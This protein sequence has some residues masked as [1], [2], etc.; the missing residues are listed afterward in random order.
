MAKTSLKTA[1]RA[2]KS[3]LEAP[4]P[5]EERD[6]VAMA[7]GYAEDVCAD[8]K[9][10]KYG[11]WI[12]L[13]A[14]RF[15]DDLKRAQVT[16]GEPPF[17]WS[18]NRANHACAFM[19]QL[20]HVEGLWGTETITLHPSQAFFL[21]NLFGF[22]N[23]DGSRRFTGALY[24]VARKNAKST[25]AAGIQ[26]YCL[27]EEREEGPQVI[28]AATTGDQA[29]IVWKIAKRMVE[30]N[31]ELREY[32]NVEEF[33]NT[34]TCWKNG[35][36]YRSINAKASTQD[37]LN[38]SCLCFDELHAHKTHDLYNVLR[39]AAG[40][41]SNPLFLYTTTEGF[42]SA[43]PWADMRAFAQHVLRGTVQADHFL[44]IYYS[45][46]DEDDDFDESKWEKANPL[47]G[48]SVKLD[49][50][51]EY[52]LEAKQ[53]PGSLSEFR[54]KRLNR[55]SAAARSWLDLARWNKCGAGKL[56]LDALAG[57]PCWAAFDLASTADMTA[58]RLL[59]LKDG[60]FYTWGRYW[61]PRDAVINR[62]NRG[63][64][65]YEPWVE[66]GW[67]KQTEGNVADYSVIEADILADCQRFQPKRVGYDL[68]NASQIAINLGKQGVN[69]ERFIQGPR[70]YSPAMQACEVA[71][72]SERLRH[73]NDPVLT[74]NMANV[75][76][77][78]DVNLNSAPDRQRSAEKIDGAAALFMAFGLAA[79]EP[80]K[81]E[82]KQFRLMVLGGAR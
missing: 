82:P 6:Y 12:R 36:T 52:A 78:H 62:N 49:K 39:S 77:R 2:S 59:W 50:L 11:A 48:V 28:S 80:P 45:L 54:I 15:L 47:L 37:G 23:H 70:S 27:V 40:A 55:R 29:R 17:L 19:E 60:I 10:V 9:R 16:R 61:V 3:A 57:I 68:W 18:P 1:S 41:R 69:L 64:V 42:E 30:K 79:S 7:L 67:I 38:P 63:T 73:G 65:R 35:G 34:V 46:D 53:Q 8:A 22:R 66:A 24:S 72:R 5:G 33:A 4:P 26:L 71:Y 25:L 74:W 75:V 81:E 31:T 13:A 56:D 43:G 51:R 14:R 32:Y 76:A 58:W 21:C 44:A 20:H